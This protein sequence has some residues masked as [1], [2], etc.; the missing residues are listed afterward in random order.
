MAVSPNTV[1][2]KSSY[3]ALSHLVFLDVAS[4]SD[5]PVTF[6][7]PEVFTNLSASSG[8]SR[9]GLFVFCACNHC[10][11]CAAT[12]FS[13]VSVCDHAAV[14]SA[15]IPSKHINVFFIDPSPYLLVEIWSK[16]GRELMT[17]ASLHWIRK[18]GSM[19]RVGD[20]WCPPWSL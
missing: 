6:P 13:A 4:V 17:D 15:S 16:V 11:S 2:F 19:E 12:A 9:S 10:C 8:A 18:G 3:S 14:A 7:S 20:F 5:L 1:T